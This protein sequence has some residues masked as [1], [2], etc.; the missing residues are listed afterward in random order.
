MRTKFCPHCASQKIH[1]VEEADGSHFHECEECQEAWEHH[2]V[3]S[4]VDLA[5]GTS[6]RIQWVRKGIGFGE[7]YIFDDGT[8]KIDTETMG[9]E[10]AKQVLCD[11]VDSAELI[12]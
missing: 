6:A 4:S 3:E 2:E 11:L 7:I 10:F 12:D 1:K 5:P 9:K 8:T